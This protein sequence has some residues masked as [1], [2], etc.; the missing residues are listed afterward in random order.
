MMP[1]R[2]RE[3]PL[4]A[5]HP[6][7]FTMG[8][9]GGLAIGIL[10]SRALARPR[11]LSDKLRERAGTVSRR[12]RP[13]R[14]HRLSFE[15]EELDQLEDMV[16]RRFLDDEI[17]SERAVDIGAI[18]A[19][20]IELS[21]FVRTEAEANRA[22]QLANATHGVRTVVNRLELG[23]VHAPRPAEASDQQMEQQAD[24]TFAHLASRTGGMGRRRQG[25]ETD[26][27]QRDDSQARREDALAAADRDQFVDEGLTPRASVMNAAP[28]VHPLPE[29]HFRDDEL[30]NQDPHDQHA[31]LTL[32]SP[33]E[34]L[35][36]DARVGEGLKPGVRR[37]LEDA[38]RNRE[39]ME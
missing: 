26:P 36:S 14:L 19:G 22:M 25:M 28:E 9:A 13:A 32:D 6:V 8:A 4:N 10:I 11:T 5:P 29:V 33:P 1:F 2:D 15:Q 7:S 30:D 21:G 18:S 23:E 37:Q 39:G 20:I 34:E 24:S 17:L 12:L 27:D 16:L 3:V 35:N 31:P 38:D